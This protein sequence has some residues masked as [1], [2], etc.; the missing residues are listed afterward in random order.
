[1]VPRFAR[2]FAFCFHTVPCFKASFIDWHRMLRNCSGNYFLKKIFR[3]WRRPG[4]DRQNV[5]RRRSRS[6]R[7]ERRTSQWMNGWRHAALSQWFPRSVVRYVARIGVLLNVTGLPFFLCAASLS[8]A[9]AR[10]S[11]PRK[12]EQQQQQQQQQQQKKN[13]T[14]NKRKFESGRTNFSIDPKRSDHSIGTQVD[15]KKRENANISQ[16]KM[17]EKITFESQR[18]WN[19]EYCFEATHWQ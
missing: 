19:I 1:M 3:K 12:M 5:S 8:V 16:S 17:V 13:D 6:G 10:R 14:E 7:H 9:C 11:L 2:C 4:R 15:W 18:N